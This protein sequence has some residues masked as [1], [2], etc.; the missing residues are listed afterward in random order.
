MTDNHTTPVCANDDTPAVAVLLHSAPEDTFGGALCEACATCTDTACGE[1][2]TILDAALLEP[3]CA[4]H[5]RQYQD[6]GEIQGPDIVLLDHD[7]A[8]WALAKGQ[9]Q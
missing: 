1:L 2:G 5:T 6:G 8:R 4:H 3:W 7:R 9:Q